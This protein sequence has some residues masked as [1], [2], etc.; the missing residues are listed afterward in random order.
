MGAMKYVS[1]AVLFVTISS[2]TGSF[3]WS[4]GNSSSPPTTEPSPEAI[5]YYFHGH[6]RCWTCKR[7]EELSRLALEEGFSDELEK[8]RLQWQVVNIEED[9]NDHFMKD[10]NLFSRAL[11]VQK[12]QDGKNAD[13]KNLQRIWELVNDEEDFVKYIQD[14]V[15]SML[16]GVQ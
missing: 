3:L 12:V 7:I 13:W 15:R 11:I 1:S 9:G 2:L 8:G 6:Q 16:G 5:V 4:E 14:E 10:Y